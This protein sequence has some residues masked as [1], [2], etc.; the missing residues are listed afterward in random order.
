[1]I[2]HSF[3]GGSAKVGGRAKGENHKRL[4]QLLTSRPRPSCACRFISIP[5]FGLSFSENL[6]L[7]PRLEKTADIFRRRWFPRKMM[8]DERAQKFHGNDGITALIKVVLPIG[9]G[10]FP[11]DTTNQR[12]YTDL[13]S[14][15]SSVR[16]FCAC[17]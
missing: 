14:E 4:F 11:R 13:G 8:S 3:F 5:N 6:S 16:N 12:H 9:Q 17:L 15:T 7:L 1:M 2:S 10:K